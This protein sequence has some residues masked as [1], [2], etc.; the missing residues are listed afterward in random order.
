M[1][2]LLRALLLRL[3]TLLPTAG[4]APS[5]AFLR[6]ATQQLHAALPDFKP[7]ELSAL[8]F[9]L[10]RWG[11][12]P[13]VGAATLDVVTQ[14][15]VESVGKSTDANDLC[16]SIWALVKLGARPSAAQL[17]LVAAAL[18]QRGL[19]RAATA[20]VSRFLWACSTCGHSPAQLLRQLGELQ[21]RVL[22]A[23]APGRPASGDMEEQGQ[24]LAS[25]AYGLGLH[26]QSVD[27]LLP[28]IERVAL[29][30]PRVLTPMQLSSEYNINYFKLY[31][32]DFS[33]RRARLPRMFAAAW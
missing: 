13:A 25:L 28:L 16:L 14:H 32:K 7:T 11:A 1:T 9:A 5:E 4:H 18:Q 30:R 20:D 29:R 15:V 24:L 22:A 2:L 12:A 26:R 21:L 6:V 10:A 33:T 3:L 27:G 23:D 8:L 17:E 19:E 31:L